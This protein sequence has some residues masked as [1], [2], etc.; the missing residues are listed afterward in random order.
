MDAVKYNDNAPWPVAPDGTGLSLAKRGIQPS[1]DA[2]S[3]SASENLGGTPGAANGHGTATDSAVLLRFNEVSAA[4][5][6][7]WVEFRIEQPQRPAA[8]LQALQAYS[9]AI[10]GEPG[11][12]AIPRPNSDASDLVLVRCDDTGLVLPPG[13]LLF[14]QGPSGEVSDAVRVEEFVKAVSVRDAAHWYYPAGAGSPGVHGVQATSPAV[15]ISEVLYHAPPSLD[16]SGSLEWVEILNDGPTS[17]DLTGWQL[18]G[19]IGFTFE[20]VTLPPNALLLVLRSVDN[21]L[22]AGTPVGTAAVGPWAGSLSNKPETIQLLDRCGNTVDEMAYFSGG[23]LWPEAANGGGATL[24]RRHSTSP[25]RWSES[26]AAGL[27]SQLSW[28]TVSYRGVAE[29]SVVGPDTQCKLT[30]NPRR[31]L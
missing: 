24:E 16:P 30:R 9:L 14:I 31:C 22:P 4:G 8:S 28:Q 26:W 18:A 29:P 2:E 25:G 23:A 1:W 19:G 7:C 3:W 27:P 12:F 13:A 21:G 11:R 17:V 10:V 20:S 15:V 6:G 5:A